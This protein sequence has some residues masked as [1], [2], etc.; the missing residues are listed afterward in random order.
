MGDPTELAL[1]TAAGQLGSGVGA[2]ERDAR[3]RRQF[4]FDPVLKLMST[5]DQ[6]DDHGFWI[7]VKGVPRRSYRCAPPSSRPT[8]RSA[9]SPRSNAVGSTGEHIRPPG[10]SFPGRRRAAT[11]RGHPAT[12]TPGEGRGPASRSS[13]GAPTNYAAAAPTGR[14]G[15]VV[16]R[17][18][19]TDS[20]TGQ[21]TQRTRDRR[22]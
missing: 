18:P 20:G 7:D 2:D 17:R 13:S 8:T 19:R 11:G 15:E 3:R 5:I 10:T 12:G 16:I 22:G 6:R 1:L 14:P 9:R 4:H 21:E